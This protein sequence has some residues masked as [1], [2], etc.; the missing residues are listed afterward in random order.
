[1]AA[2]GAISET[3]AANPLGVSIIIPCHNSAR[4]LPETL[5]HL[6]NQ[7]PTECAWEI[8]I[9]DN[10]STDD[11]ATVARQLWPDNL[12][13]SLRVVS[14]SAPGAGPARQKGVQEARYEFLGFVDHDNWVCPTWVRAAYQ[15]MLSDPDIALCG[16]Y[17]DGEF[18]T[19]PPAWFSHVEHLYA[20]GPRLEPGDI[21]LRANL[22]TAGL[23]V[24]RSALLELF[25]AGFQPLLT[26]RLGSKLTSGEDSELTYAIRLAG[27]KIWLDSELHFLHYMPSAR[28]NW[29]YLRKLCYGSAL[30]TPAHDAF[31]SLQKPPR[32]GLLKLARRARET[33]FWQLISTA[34]RTVA[35]PV[36]L[37]RIADDY[38]DD[39]PTLSTEMSL[40]R[41]E[42]LWQSRRWYNSRPGQLRSLINS[43]QS[44][45]SQKATN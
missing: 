40:A 3:V 43:H 32:K 1:M 8:I 7:E 2:N 45:K 23:V 30:A 41:L 16:S 12:P 25:R 13:I 31:F 6:R 18:E 37:A 34:I 9:V 27:W 15:R 28:L 19:A 29:P 39:F 20:I 21:T 36:H 35:H 17:S 5:K 33:W 22:W 24:R 4:F 14:E 38:Q 42:G 44:R 10:G 26:G 11:T